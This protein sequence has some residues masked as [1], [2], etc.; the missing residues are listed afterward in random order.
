MDE[1]EFLPP[2]KETLE[3]NLDAM[4]I[5]E[6]EQ[7]IA[8]LRAEIARAQATIE[9]RQQVRSGADAVFKKS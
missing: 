8:D 4:S 7:Y 5:E 3:K 6:L 2:Q 1:D 9:A